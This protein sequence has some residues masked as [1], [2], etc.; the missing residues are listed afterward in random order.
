[1]EDDKNLNSREEIAA[2]TKN[3]IIIHPG[4]SGKRLPRPQRYRSFP[5]LLFMNG[6]PYRAQ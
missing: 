2:K 4:D 5:A 3:F 1:M 6:K